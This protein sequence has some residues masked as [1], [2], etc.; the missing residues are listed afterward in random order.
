[1]SGN[2]RGALGA[3]VVVTSLFFAWGFITSII[4]PLIAAVRGIYSLSY[5][6]ALLTQFAF[7]IS[8][9]VISLPAAALLTKAGHVRTILLALAAM[10]AACLIILLATFAETYQLVLF[11]LFV[12]GSGITAL[13]VAANPLAATLGPPERSHLR[14]VFSQAFNSLGTVLGPYLGAQL[15]LQGSVHEGG[16]ADAAARTEALG[17]IHTAFLVIAGLMALLILFIW[18]GRRRLQAAAP[19]PDAYA[20]PLGAMRS[21]WGLFGALAIFLYVGAEVS[22]GSLL[23]NFLHQPDVLDVPLQRALELVALYWGGAMV[24]RFVGS[25]LLLRFDAANLLTLFATIAVALCLFVFASGGPVAG[26][27]AIAIGLFNS[28]MFPTI[29]TLTLERSTASHAATSGLLCVAIVGGAF[30]P[31]LYG[32][33]A[34]ARGIGFAF[35]VPAAAY[36]VIVLF[37]LAARRARIVGAAAPGA[38]AH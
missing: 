13:Q 23:G 31:Q 2:G 11:G 37:A 17:H 25:A 32:N 18:A 19:A 8:Y 10:L 21:R 15:M 7:F 6:E 29:F 26:Y 34:D 33:V 38:V 20:S 1:M 4:D 16:A 12:M 36:A 30:L 24:G 27:A 14:L 3:F 28:I 35:I 5:R 9:G 22:I